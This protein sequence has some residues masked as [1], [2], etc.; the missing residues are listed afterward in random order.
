MI[1]LSQP[2]TGYI[3][4]VY[5]LVVD[6]WPDWID[7]LEDFFAAFSRISWGR[8]C[9]VLAA[10]WPCRSILP[11]SIY[12]THPLYLFARIHLRRAQQILIPRGLSPYGAVISV[13]LLYYPISLG[14]PWGFGQLTL[15][16]IIQKPS[17]VPNADVP[18][19]T[20]IHLPAFESFL[21]DRHIKI[22]TQH[23]WFR[24]WQW[25]EILPIFCFVL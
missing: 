9:L 14:T 2:L 11:T 4:V 5:P 3:V 12:C 10:P 6:D 1:N 7:Q 18:S 16:A 19:Y 25:H 24:V 21:R 23:S 8:P 22:E 13:A 15:Q 20:T 17:W